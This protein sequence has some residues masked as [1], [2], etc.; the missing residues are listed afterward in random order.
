MYEL[1]WG[2]GDFD[3]LK[4]LIAF[5]MMNQAIGRTCGYR[6]SDSEQ[7]GNHVAVVLCAP[8]LFKQLVKESRYYIA[9]AKDIDESNVYRKLTDDE[10]IQSSVEWLLHNYTKYVV[11]GV[12]S[13]RPLQDWLADVRGCLNQVSG[14]RRIQRWKRLEKGLQTLM[15]NARGGNL[16][17]FEKAIVKAEEIVVELT[18]VTAGK[19]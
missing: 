3:A 4:H 14:G 17:A 6:Y 2:L 1:D 15:E 11:R 9:S 5:D 10:T 12:K 18:S 8:R 7:A 16:E 19:P 13:K